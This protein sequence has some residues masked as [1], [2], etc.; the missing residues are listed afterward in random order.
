MAPPVVVYKG[1]LPATIVLT[2]MTPDSLVVIDLS[3]NSVKVTKTN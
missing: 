3:K 1:Q 2:P